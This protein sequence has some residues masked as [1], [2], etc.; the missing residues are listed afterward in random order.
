MNEQNE[1]FNYFFQINLS[2]SGSEHGKH[3]EDCADPISLK[4]FTF[5]EQ[6]FVP[7]VLYH[8]LWVSLSFSPTNHKIVLYTPLCRCKRQYLQKS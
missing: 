5:R 7:G 1:I 6:L 2:V 3:G 8:I 4:F